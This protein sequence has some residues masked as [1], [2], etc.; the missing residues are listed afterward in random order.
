VRGV[1]A[2][3]LLMS[4]AQALAVE[5]VDILGDDIQLAR[6]AQRIISLA[7]HITE[8]LFAAGVGARIVG[9]DA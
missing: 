4:A 8:L 2:A 5:S 3:L 7:P 9:A 1:L 6:P